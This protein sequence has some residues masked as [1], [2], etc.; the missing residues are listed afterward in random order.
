M[1][2]QG[3]CVQ[4]KLYCERANPTYRR[5]FKNNQDKKHQICQDIKAPYSTIE[6][7]FFDIRLQ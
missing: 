5:M 7:N 6:Y 2:Y 4:Y 1:S 3:Q